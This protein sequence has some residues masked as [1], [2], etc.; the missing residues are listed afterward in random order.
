MKIGEL[1]KVTGL[2]PSRIRFYEA[3]GLISPPQRQ[4]NGYRNYSAEV[5]NLLKIIDNAQRAGFSLGQIRCF[6]PQE[7]KKWDHEGLIQS[8]EKRIAEIELMQKQLEE[9]KS[10]LLSLI[11]SIANRPDGISCEDNMQRLI[12][13]LRNPAT[14]TENQ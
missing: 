6:L 4:S 11:A 5:A 3:E 9:S 7:Q 2:T 10:E 13:Q 12:G 8:L 1:A 14:A